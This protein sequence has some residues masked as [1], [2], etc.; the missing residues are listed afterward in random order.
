M[1]STPR[2][3]GGF[4]SGLG[5]GLGASIVGCIG[6]CWVGCEG[7]V[8]GIWF[9]EGLL[10]GMS[11]REGGCAALR[12]VRGTLRDSEFVRVPL[13]YLGA[14]GQMGEFL[15]LLIRIVRPS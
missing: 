8:E 10:E 12:F 13:T 6:V 5:E 2:P 9:R 3:Q 15:V 4:V 14:G 11:V 7:L 1:T